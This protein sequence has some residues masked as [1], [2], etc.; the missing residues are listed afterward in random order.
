MF[1]HGAKERFV[2]EDQIA[3]LFVLEKIDEAIAPLF[4][5]RPDDKVD[6]FRAEL[7]S[8]VGP[9]HLH[10]PIAASSADGCFSE[11]IV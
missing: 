11:T 5:Q 8:A 6:V 4:S 7:R 3:A 1:E 2:I 9:Y 10:T